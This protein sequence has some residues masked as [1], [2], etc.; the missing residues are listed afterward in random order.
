METLRHGPVLTDTDAKQFLATL[1]LIEKYWR[2]ELSQFAPPLLQPDAIFEHIHKITQILNTDQ[3]SAQRDKF[4]TQDEAIKY[5]RDIGAFKILYNLLLSRNESLDFYLN[6]VKMSIALYRNGD[7][8]RFARIAD[9]KKLD[10]NLKAH[11][12]WLGREGEP[13]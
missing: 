13:S 5:L 12:M 2:K 4:M 7:G 1:R 11:Y 3:V 8:G 10:D 6:G 9:L